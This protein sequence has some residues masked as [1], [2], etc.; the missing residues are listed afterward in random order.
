MQKRRGAEVARIV[1]A[2]ARAPR[3]AGSRLGE[4]PTLDCRHGVHE[5]PNFKFRIFCHA[6]YPNR[7]RQIEC[8]IFTAPPKKPTSSTLA[9][10]AGQKPALWANDWPKAKAAAIP[11][12]A[13]IG[14]T[15]LKVSRIISPMRI[16]YQKKFKAAV[17]ISPQLSPALPVFLMTHAPPKKDHKTGSEKLRSECPLEKSLIF[18]RPCNKVPPAKAQKFLRSLSVGILLHARGVVLISRRSPLWDGDY[19]ALKAQHA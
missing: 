11:A 17:H 15:C 14:S 19:P 7:A 8:T 12:A 10:G 2:K 18:R 4:C 6:C 13:K 3:I 9:V 16:L 5:P 1:A